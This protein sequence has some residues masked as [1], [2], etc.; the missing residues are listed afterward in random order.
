MCRRPVQ[1]ALYYIRMSNQALI[2]L[3]PEYWKSASIQKVSQIGPK[4]VI[5]YK[6]VKPGFN[7]I[8]T[9]ILEVCEYSECVADRSKGLYTI[10]ECQIRL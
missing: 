1:R 10:A 8:G 5:L 2:L 6:N 4:G 7:I 9:G 3:E